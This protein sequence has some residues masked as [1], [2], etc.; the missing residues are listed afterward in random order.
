MHGKPKYVQN[1]VLN[2]SLSFVRKIDHPF[3][4]DNERRVAKREVKDLLWAMA[5]MGV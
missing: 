1:I 2:L 3:I 5:M 4:Q